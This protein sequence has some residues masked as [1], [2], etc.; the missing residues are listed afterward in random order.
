MSKR[1]RAD[2]KLESNKG[3]PKR[4]SGNGTG[5]DKATKARSFSGY[6]RSLPQLLAMAI[7]ETAY[8][9]RLIIITCSF[10][11]AIFLGLTIVALAL[12]GVHLSHRLTWSLGLFGAASAIVTG[13]IK[14][15]RIVMNS[16]S[17]GSSDEESDDT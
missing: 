4:P 1:V 9:V 5:R 8:T 2:K 16:E 13:V 10:V 12:R 11:L 17:G 6:P 7:E 14:V 15:V 3:K